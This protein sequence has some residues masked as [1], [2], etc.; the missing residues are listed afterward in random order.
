MIPIRFINFTSITVNLTS[1][2]TYSPIGITITATVQIPEDTV[3]PPS[4][5]TE[6]TLDYFPQVVEGTFYIV[7]APVCRIAKRMDFVTPD[8]THR[9]C[10]RGEGG[11]VTAVP[12]FICYLPSDYPIVYVEGE[13][14]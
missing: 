8:Y 12:H 11:N 7:T 9:N 4:T 6:F 2:E 5:P 1:G 10:A 14:L 13:N 3:I